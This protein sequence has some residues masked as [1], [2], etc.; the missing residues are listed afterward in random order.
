MYR[1]IKLMGNELLGGE[2]IDE[3]YSVPGF[4]FAN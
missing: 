3:V 1:E 4:D 2:Q